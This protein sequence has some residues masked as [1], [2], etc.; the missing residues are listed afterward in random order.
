[1]ASLYDLAKNSNSK[2]VPQYI[3][4]EAAELQ[5]VGD[6]LDQRYRRNKDLTDKINVLAAQT[7]VRDVDQAVKEAR[8][9]QVR[10]DIEGIASSPENFE[11]STI[12]AQN[13]AQGF[14]TDQQ[15][16]DAQE[17]F[18]REQE[19]KEFLKKNP[20]AVVFASGDPTQQS[21]VDA[22]GNS[23]LIDFNAQ[24]NLDKNKKFK[25]IIGKVAADGY[26]YINGRKV[27]LDPKEIASIIGGIQTGKI[28]NVSKEK[29]DGLIELALGQYETS[30]EG[31]QHVAQ[32]ETPN[33]INQWTARGRQETEIPVTEKGK[34]LGTIK[35]N[36]TRDAIRDEFKSS[37]YPQ[38]FSQSDIDFRPVNPDWFNGGGGN[39]NQPPTNR[40]DYEETP[41]I[42]YHP[43]ILDDNKLN[44]TGLTLGQRIDPIVQ[45]YNNFVYD[46]DADIYKI[47]GRIVRRTPAMDENYAKL[48][49][50]YTNYLKENKVGEYPK[51]SE[52]EQDKFNRIVRNFKPDADEAF[53]KSD[54]AYE[55]VKNYNRNT[56][57][58]E[59]NEKT[60]IITGDFV[61]RGEEG[62]STREDATKD[63]QVNYKYRSFYDPKT[64]ETISGSDPKLYK[65]FGYDS[66]EDMVKDM[67]VV[68]EYSPKNLFT[69]LAQSDAFVDP[70]AVRIGDRELAMSRS[71]G[72]LSGNT[73]RTRKIVNDVYR[74]LKELPGIPN[75]V[76]IEGIDFTVGEI[77]EGPNKYIVLEDGKGGQIV[78][79]DLEDLPMALKQH[80]GKTE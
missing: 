36:S 27:Q 21:T 30:A 24:Q 4:S 31:L 64:G 61:R 37:I 65:K 19:Y 45:R 73:Y 17:N 25:E 14:F 26:T 7:R 29:V 72:E 12:A 28:Q 32:I 60:P 1:M 15:L 40:P 51:M 47:N 10:Q 62:R 2:F 23:R 11:N 70:V 56:E 71:K 74:A 53:L 48:Q 78:V 58:N 6:T 69:T 22:E 68:G 55:I 52:E 76:S 39:G 20:G 13:I 59:F 75:K 66:K 3:G 80:Y 9:N 54:A 33:N 34:L 16:N 77:Q 41:G 79:Q 57:Q 67:Q 50:D 49:Q 8:I 44:R 43:K 5:Q 35:S 42:E 46:K 18:R 63:A 38:I